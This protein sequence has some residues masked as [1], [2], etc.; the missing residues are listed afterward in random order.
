MTTHN[1]PRRD[2]DQGGYSLIEIVLVLTLMA[3]VLALAAPDMSGFVRGNRLGQA[4]Q[5]LMGDLAAARM[6]AVRAGQ[7]STL[8]VLSPTSYEITV[9][10][11]STP[12]VKRVDF[13]DDFPS[14][15]L[16]GIASMTFNSRGFATA[17]TGTGT[18]FTL[19]LGDDSDSVTVTPVGRIY[20]ND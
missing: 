5:V 2:L 10:G 17:T 14:V 19:T 16:G 8:T 3:I 18:A 6:A 4:T 7:S 20:R 9:V 12:P 13:S 1:P 15:S 11:D